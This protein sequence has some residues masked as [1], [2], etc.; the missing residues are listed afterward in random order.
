MLT[1]I[2]RHQDCEDGP[3]GA[4]YYMI[5][6]GQRDREPDL[7]DDKLKGEYK[8]DKPEIKTKGDTWAENISSVRCWRDYGGEAPK[9]D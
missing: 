7:A 4:P 6:Q 5:R 2:R 1:T 8:S 9:R 3:A